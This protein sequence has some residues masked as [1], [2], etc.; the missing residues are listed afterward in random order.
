VRRR[1]GDAEHLSGLVEREPAEEPE[2]DD[3]RLP[4]AQPRQVVERIVQ[5]DEVASRVVGVVQVAIERH[6]RGATAALGRL[7]GAG[8]INEDAPHQLRG[9]R[10]ELRPTFESQPARLAQT[11]ERLVDERRRL[12][13]MVGA[14]ATEIRLRNTAQLRVDRGRGAVE[15]VAVALLPALEEMGY[16]DRVVGVLRRRHGETIPSPVSALDRRRWNSAS[17]PIAESATTDGSGTEPG[18]LVMV[19]NG[20]SKVAVYSSTP[21]HASR[22]GSAATASAAASSLETVLSMAS[23]R[24]SSGGY[25]SGNRRPVVPSGASTWSAL[26]SLVRYAS[27]AGSFDAPIRCSSI[28]L[29]ALRP[30]QSPT[31]SATVRAAFNSALFL[32]ARFSLCQRTVTQPSLLRRLSSF[33]LAALLFAPIGAVAAPIVIGGFFTYLSGVTLEAFE[34]AHV[35]LGTVGSA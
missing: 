31:R 28:A 30:G 22:T 14:L 33:V 32:S 16:I 23:S 35:S 9:E 18:A 3:A 7:D 26:A 29:A 17:A 8:V 12:Q 5:R 1:L 20:P 15:G 21:A 6:L 10:K 11:H 27:G 2:L 4:C 13:R 19:A 24:K 34:G 25:T